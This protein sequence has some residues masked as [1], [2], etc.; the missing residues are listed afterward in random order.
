M[1]KED[2]HLRTMKSKLKIKSYNTKQMVHRMTM[3]SA[4]KVLRFK[5]VTIERWLMIPK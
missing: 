5:M 2:K 1:S 3:I 4:K